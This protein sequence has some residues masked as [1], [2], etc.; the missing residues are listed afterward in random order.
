MKKFLCG[1]FCALSWSG[2][3]R[4]LP[5]PTPAP[6]P[7]P[8]RAARVADFIST[9]GVNTHLGYNDGAYAD[10]GRVIRD[11]AYLGI[12]Q[13][14]DSTPNPNGGSPYHAYLRSIATAVG[15]GIRF[16]FIVDPSLPI[17]ISL[18]QI[19]RVQ[20][21]A[22]DAVASI[23]GPNEINNA[24]VTY[25]ELT[26]EAA[27]EAFQRDLYAGVR[28]NPALENHP[29]FYLTGGRAIDLRAHPGLAD[30]ANGHPYPYRG[31]S[32]GPRIAGEFQTYFTMPL[33]YAR[34]ITETGYFN[35]PDDP[36]GSGVDSATQARLTLDLLF[37]AFKQ[38]VSRTY[39]YQLLSAYPDPGHHSPD[40]EY[41]LFNQDSSP[42]PVAT[43]IHQLTALLADTGPSAGS[44]ATGS[45]AYAV[46][47]FPATGHSV[48]LQQSG[49]TYILVL[50]AE[51]GIWNE[52]AHAPVAAPPSQVIVTLATPAALVQADDPLR[53]AA[54]M[55]TYPHTDTITLSLTDHPI[56]LRIRP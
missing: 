17:P 21:Q 4:A 39:L 22:P 13:V 5:G 20:Q 10:V 19:A 15:A 49:G 54:T 51:P 12:R 46:T 38:G 48:L 16:D 3:A 31:A 24:P 45:L 25:Q 28:A 7:A 34:V 26:G 33:P 30:Y 41:G 29:V 23:E 42:K 32:P 43:A 52:A 35:Q 9:L 36:A 37:D 1:M 56:L 8:V 55:A 11:L 2:T 47:G 53:S 27:A 44:F 14:R 18:D 40:N 50:W 6:A